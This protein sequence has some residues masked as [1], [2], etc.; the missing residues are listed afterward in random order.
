MSVGYKDLRET[1]GLAGRV[2]QLRPGDP[3]VA[4]DW[5]PV[6]PIANYDVLVR[7]EPVFHPIEGKVVY[8]PGARRRRGVTKIAVRT[9]ARPDLLELFNLAVM[10]KTELR[11]EISTD[12]LRSHGRRPL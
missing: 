5:I 6:V 8:F 10:M 4:I 2:Y 3:S 7:G 12:R 1:K 9:G 11:S